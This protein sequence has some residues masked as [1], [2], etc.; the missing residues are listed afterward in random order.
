MIQNY[1][2]KL[3]SFH[4]DACPD[5]SFH[6]DADADVDPDPAFQFVADVDPDPDLASQND[7]DLGPDADCKHW[8]SG[9]RTNDINLLLNLNGISSFQGADAK[10]ENNWF[11]K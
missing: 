8:S 7:A 10:S 11:G 1:P 5:S 4:L 9:K 2:V 6:F 3:P